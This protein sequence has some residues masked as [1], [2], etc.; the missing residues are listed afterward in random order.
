VE[1]GDDYFFDD[2]DLNAETFDRGFRVGHSRKSETSLYNDGE[3]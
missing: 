2:D 3:G 1:V